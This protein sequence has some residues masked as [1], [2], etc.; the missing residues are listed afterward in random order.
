MRDSTRMLKMQMMQLEDV[1]KTP[2]YHQSP[3]TADEAI[4]QFNELESIANGYQF[5]FKYVKYCQGRNLHAYLAIN[6][7]YNKSSMENFC[8]SYGISYT[9]ARRLNNFAI[10]IYHHQRYEIFFN[11]FFH[12]FKFFI[13]S[14]IKILFLIVFYIFLN[15]WNKFID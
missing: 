13:H 15:R 7:L 4:A 8:A 5:A 9:A 12:N 6:K 11:I 3:N 2:K 10:F 1:M 14:L